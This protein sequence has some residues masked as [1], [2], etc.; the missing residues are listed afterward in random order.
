MK[1]TVI[2]FLNNIPTNVRHPWQLE[3][4]AADWNAI[5]DKFQPRD[6]AARQVAMQNLYRIFRKEAALFGWDTTHCDALFH[7]SLLLRNRKPLTPG[8][9]R[10]KFGPGQKSP[11]RLDLETQI[12]E[13][14]IGEA[15][16]AATEGFDLAV[17]DLA[18]AL[19]E[20]RLRFES[21]YPDQKPAA[22]CNMFREALAA[23]TALSGFP[24]TV[25]DAIHG[26][27][28]QHSRT[29]I[30]AQ[31][32]MPPSR[33][34]TYQQTRCAQCEDFLDPTTDKHFGYHKYN[35]NLLLYCGPCLGKIECGLRRPQKHAVAGVT[36]GS[37]L[38]SL[39][40]LTIILLIAAFI[41]A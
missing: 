30:N 34:A 2:A 21:S 13:T 1:E 17:T 14:L 23:V 15:R 40:A 11:M 25:R 16:I 35:D 22:V 19:F 24:S 32:P 12:T 8:T 6:K 38:V 20:C 18:P 39:A 10:N 27:Y 41:L 37:L 31:T 3:D 9:R 29:R 33:L 4:I 36:A 28:T 26:A 5:R 7:L